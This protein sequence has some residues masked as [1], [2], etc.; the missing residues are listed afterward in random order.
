MRQSL[1]RLESELSA[2]HKRQLDIQKQESIKEAQKMLQDFENAQV[3]L[4]RQ[5]EEKDQL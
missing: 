1:T 2:K 3:F 4:K 5:M